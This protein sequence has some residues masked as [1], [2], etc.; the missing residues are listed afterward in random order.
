[1]T[2]DDPDRFTLTIHGGDA[3]L[4]QL[5]VVRELYAEIYA[6]RRRHPSGAGMTII[7]PLPCARIQPCACR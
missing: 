3:G 2:A 5:G 7:N 6:V 1:M 4:A